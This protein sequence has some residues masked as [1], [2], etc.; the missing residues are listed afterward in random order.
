MAQ[1][2]WQLLD[3]VSDRPAEPGTDGRPFPLG[4]AGRAGRPLRR[5]VRAA[6]G[7]SDTVRRRP[8]AGA[9]GRFAASDGTRPIAG[10]GPR[11][12]PRSPDARSDSGQRTPRQA[13]AYG[14]AVHAS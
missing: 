4:V 8:A 5:G 12:Q 14:L 7:A 13:P 10:P 2:G 3:A 6:L 1:S 9:F 11:R